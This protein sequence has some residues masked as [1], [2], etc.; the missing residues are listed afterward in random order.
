[1]YIKFKNQFAIQTIVWIVNWFLSLI[2]IVKQR[3][4]QIQQSIQIL[5]LNSDNSS[6]FLGGI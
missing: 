3:I 6:Y 4:L 1:M 5:Q 2:Y